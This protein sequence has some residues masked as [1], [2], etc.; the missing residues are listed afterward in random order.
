M[1]DK[2]VTIEA[3]AHSKSGVRTSKLGSEDHL[4]TKIVPV[5]DVVRLLALIF[6]HA[7]QFSSRVPVP[8]SPTSPESMAT[9][10]R[11]LSSTTRPQSS[12]SVP[13]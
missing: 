9:S 4:V 2:E 10:L 1:D 6:V 12:S 13:L 11:P 3:P 8:F 5:F 7:P